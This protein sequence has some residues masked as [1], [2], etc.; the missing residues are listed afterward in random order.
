MITKNQLIEG[1]AKY[2][3][4]ELLPSL[5]GWQMWVGGAV[6]NLAKMNADKMLDNLMSHKMAIA[7]GIVSEDSMIDIDKAYQAFSGVDNPEPITV[8]LG[9]FGKYTFKTDDIDV[10]YDYLLNASSGRQ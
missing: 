4:A 3:S 2:I 7:L 5:S 10:L 1:V 6:I 8:D 9:A